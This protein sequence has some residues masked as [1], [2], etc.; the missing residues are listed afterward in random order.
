MLTQSTPFLERLILFL[1]PYFL[2]ATGDHDAARAEIV[3]TIASYGPR[4]RAEMINAVQIIAFSFSALDVLAEAS[5]ASGMSPAQRLRHRGCA[6]NLNRSARQNEDTL[7]ARL[8]AKVPEM[9][10]LPAEPVDDVSEAAFEEALQRAQTQITAY[11]SG[12]GAT[13]SAA[14]PP[15]R[16]AS[17]PDQDQWLPEEP[18]INAVTQRGIPPRPASAA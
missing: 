10:D 1:M 3:E 15:A 18:M 6:N 11:R 7:A 9:A 17:R 2:T 4:T 16:S 5:A 12:V 13:A 14:L 8:A